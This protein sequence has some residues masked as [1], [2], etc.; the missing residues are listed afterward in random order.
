MNK[1]LIGRYRV[2]VSG[3]CGT[4]ASNIANISALQELTILSQSPKQVASNFT[5]EIS[6]NVYAAG[7]DPLRYQW[8]RNGV[9]LDGETASVFYKNNVTNAD[10]GTYWCIISD[11]CDTIVSDTMNVKLFPVSVEDEGII[12]E[13][14]HGLLAIMPNPATDNIQARIISLMPGEVTFEIHSIFGSSMVTPL[15]VSLDKGVNMVPI[16]ID[17]LPSGTYLCTMKMN[18]VLTSHTFSI[19]K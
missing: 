14:K 8:Y 13:N 2:I 3:I 12:S 7:V 15:V 9:K 10:S 17:G 11:R 1:G 4:T 16:N 18:G 19:V 6:L 5:K